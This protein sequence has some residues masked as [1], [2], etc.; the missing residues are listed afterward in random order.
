MY[1]RRL[2]SSANFPLFDINYIV[3]INLILVVCFV[4]L[5]YMASV[6]VVFVFVNTHHTRKHFA[7]AHF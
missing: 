1:F 3:S 4:F 7:H 6:N 5:F 2:T